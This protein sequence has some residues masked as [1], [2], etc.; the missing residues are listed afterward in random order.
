MTWPDV[1]VVGAA[2]CGTTS[3]HAYLGQH[4]DV[5]V[6]GRKE[7]HYYTRDL[8]RKNLAG[9]G[10]EYTLRTIARSEADYCASFD[11]AADHQRIADV[12][13]S[14]LYWYEVARQIEQ[15]QPDARIIILLRDPV[16]KAY[17][18][19]LHQVRAQLETL[20]FEDAIAAEAERAASGWSDVWYYVQSSRYHEQVGHYLK[21][22]GSERVLVVVTEEL[23]AEPHSVMRQVFEFLDVS[24]DIAV[25]ETMR[26]R[27][28]AV[29][30]PRLAR[31][32]AH[33][34]RV[35]R[36]SHVLPKSLRYRLALRMIELNTGTKPDIS[37]SLREALGREFAA[38]V[39]ALEE[40]LERKLPWT[41]G[42][43][44]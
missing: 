36:L 24:P 42:A 37:D 9:P 15:D 17:S 40:L 43:V 29:R 16:E 3:M 2:K 25:S 21:V 34:N 31:L 7:L 39:H 8:L 6:A 20:S 44:H 23:A 30:S 26:N 4:P 35:K 12:S 13:P 41:T 14:Y 22:F 33:P 10:D 1:F 19:W 32:I 28:G 38:D 5:F 18:Q 27:S 11:G